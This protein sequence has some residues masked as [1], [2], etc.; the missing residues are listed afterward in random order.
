[1]V[2]DTQQLAAIYEEIKNVF[3]HH[4]SISVKPTKGNPPEQY[5]ASY[6]IRG[7]YKDDSGRI[8]HSTNHVV[9]IT[10][11]FGFPHFPPSCKPKTP[12][13]HPDFDPAAICLGD[14]WQHDRSI[15]ELII[16]IGKMIAGEIFSRENTFNED[17][18][19]WYRENADNLPF[20]KLEGLQKTAP[21]T[22]PS[23]ASLNESIE[24]DTLEDDDFTSDFN[25]LGIDHEKE[26]ESTS[27]H[28]VALAIGASPDFDSE[29][30][31]LL[32]R[33]KRYFQL[34][35]ILKNIADDVV[36]EG[37]EDLTTLI[38]DSI[39]E[40]RKIY[41][42]GEELEQRGFPAKALEKYRDVEEKVS[43]Y[44]KIQEDIR[45]T[46][47]AKDLLGDWIQGGEQS[48]I[49]AKQH[50]K[51]GKKLERSQAVDA[52]SDDRGVT[53]YS[54]KHRKHVNVVPFAIFIGLAVIITPLLYIYFS[55]TNQYKRA[56]QLYS[57]CT[58]Q[59]RSTQ[60][61]EA[62][63]SCG[64]AITL[65]KEVTFIK[66]QESTELLG[67]LD[68][69]LNSEEMRQGL[70]GNVL[71]NGN[72]IP[73]AVAES[74]RNSQKVIKEGDSF[75]EAADWKNA[76]E[77][78][79][80]V[81]KAMQN[82]P[83]IE[84]AIKEELNNKIRRAQANLSI[85]E[86]NA[87]MERQQWQ[88]ALDHFQKALNEVQAYPPEEKKAYLSSLQN[89]ID[90]CT[91]LLLKQQGEKMFASSNWT[92]AFSLFQKAIQLGAKLDQSE[93]TALNSIQADAAKAGLYS[94]I[95]EGKMSFA[96][97]D[98]NEAIRKYANASKILMDNPGLLSQA[99]TDLSLKKLTRIML[100][101]SIIR[102]QEQAEQSIEAKNYEEAA[103][104]LQQV[105]DTIDESHL[106]KEK[107][108]ADF[109]KNAFELLAK[110]KIEQQVSEKIIYLEQN[111]QA[112]FAQNYPVA[113]Q[114]SL[115]SPVITFVKEEKD[116]LLFRLQCTENGRGKPFTLVMFYSYDKK[117]EK[118]SFYSTADK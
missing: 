13:F 28:S 24:I 68:A 35:D 38:R 114:D 21:I 50:S 116:K 42:E 76:I 23:A 96:N 103:K 95:N 71:V 56:E 90:K 66:K 14:F 65:A 19:L 47:Q 117:T 62:S 80:L 26:T 91:F 33:Q 88:Q 118:W 16:F 105:I 25:L 115:S 32:S 110:V 86:G 84:A 7:I 17:A 39:K 79:S 11:P 60:F 51:N 89:L 30:I 36:F 94:T 12:I 49:E 61:K 46:E 5:E 104:L 44:P 52:P 3:N 34:R 74:L 58:K 100:Q 81:L 106:G 41:N 2:A 10:I 67:K 57:D 77:S 93:S 73:I 4:P 6:T 64:A 111:F 59:L 78:Y 97:R 43:D 70:S 75:A 87:S 48:Q 29:T 98:W 63:Q 45:R 102:D 112:L 18:A 37:K 82:D 55:N 8:Q 15:S 9:S 92:E 40:A 83:K 109:R 108:I 72:Y 1:M 53:M 85:Q 99:E 54:E 69:L 22:S 27:D 31:W 107:E 101:A 113:S 20:A